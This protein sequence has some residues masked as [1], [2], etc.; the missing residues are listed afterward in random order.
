MTLYKLLLLKRLPL[1]FFTW[2]TSADLSRLTQVLQ[3]TQDLPKSGFM[4][5]LC[6]PHIYYYVHMYI[7]GD[8]FVVAV[9]QSLGHVQLFMIP[10]TTHTKLPCPSLSP[11]VFSNSCPL[12]QW[13]HPTISSSVTP[14]PSCPQSFPAS[15]SFPFKTIQGYPL[16]WQ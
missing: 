16:S 13:C 4:A 10:W 9:V 3:P 2:I 14:F 12:S 11:K 8:F 1:R 15:G 6:S 5:F 7:I